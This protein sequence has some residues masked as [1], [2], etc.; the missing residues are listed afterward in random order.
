MKVKGWVYISFLIVALILVTPHFVHA[1]VCNDVLSG[2]DQSGCPDPET[3]KYV[4]QSTSNNRLTI[5]SQVTAKHITWG[6]G[7]SC[8]QSSGCYKNSDFNGKCNPTTFVDGWQLKNFDYNVHSPGSS[9][10]FTFSSSPSIPFDLSDGQTQN[11]NIYIDVKSNAPSQHYTIDIGMLGDLSDSVRP[12]YTLDFD[13]SGN[14]GG[15]TDKCST[16]G[17]KQCSGAGYQLCSD[18][19]SDGC[20]EWSSV[21]SCSTAICKTPKCS[22]SGTCGFNNVANGATDGSCNGNTG[23]SGGSCVC[24]GQGTCISSGPSCSDDC[25]TS[26]A[27]ACVDSTTYHTCGQYDSDSC[28]DW[29]SATSCS[30]GPC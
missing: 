28:L 11:F 18:S 26:G 25:P 19:N 30:G 8:T 16:N 4:S 10:Y 12:I 7:S 15:C 17:A 13:W 9:S 23:C 1:H 29:S 5:V 6:S 21:N 24:N 14:G 3:V 22:G 20:L 27:H 2:G